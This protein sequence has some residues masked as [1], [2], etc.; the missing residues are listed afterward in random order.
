MTII[1]GTIHSMVYQN[2]ISPPNSKTR[3]CVTVGMMTTG[4]LYR[5]FK[6]LYDETNLPPS[7]FIQMK[8][9]EQD[10][11]FAIMDYSI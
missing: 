8:G 2:L 11:Y 9:G 4:G 7:E 3:V 5:Y 10:A 1:L 6:Y